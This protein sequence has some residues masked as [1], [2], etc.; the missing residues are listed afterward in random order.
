MA[1]YNQVYQRAFYYD[2]ALKRDVSRE[3]DFIMAVYRH[4]TG[5]TLQSVLDIACGPGY[6]ARALAQRGVRAVGLD[7]RPEMLEFAQE[8]AAA[9]GVQVEWLAADMRNFQLDPPVEMAL[10][11]FDG[12]DALLTNH[13]IRQ[14]LRTVAANLTPGGLYL[15]EQTHPRDSSYQHYGKFRYRGKQ[16]GTAVDLIWAVNNPAFDLTT[17]VAQVEIEMRIKQNRHR[18]IIRDTARERLL[19][20]QELRLL[21]EQ[22]EV[23]QI[24]GWYG[25][26]DLDQPLDNSPNS[27]RLLTVL[28]KANKED[29]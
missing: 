25:N 28:Q 26:F 19:L 27:R 29:G 4:W 7:L 10:C 16:N 15:L 2:I 17:G 5:S 1:E 12:L 22:T 23:F 9:E 8:Q 13:D 11:M 18:Q 24:V 21:V 3:V 6:H 20:P 14:H